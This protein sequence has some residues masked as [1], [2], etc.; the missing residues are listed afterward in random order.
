MRIIS[1]LTGAT[2]VPLPRLTAQEPAFVR[3]RLTHRRLAGARGLHPDLRSQLH[4]ARPEFAYSHRWQVWDLVIWNYRRTMHR[5]RP[6]DNTYPRDLRR[7]TKLDMCSTL[8]EA[9]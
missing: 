5:G 2:G 8:D 3:A 7:A 9:A 6:H 4:A 1:A